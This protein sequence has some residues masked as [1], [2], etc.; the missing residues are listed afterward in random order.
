[1][2]RLPG[3]TGQRHLILEKTTPMLP[4]ARSRGTGPNPGLISAARIEAGESVTPARA[5]A[6]RQRKEAEKDGQ[7]E[8]SRKPLDQD[9]GQKLQIQKGGNIA[10]A[11]KGPLKRDQKGQKTTRIAT[12]SRGQY[13][14]Q[15]RL[16]A[17]VTRT[18]GTVCSA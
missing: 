4:E 16:V 9:N 18:E 5:R 3:E 14:T 13:S 17:R 12:E 15:L 10:S 1:M 7:G 6:S 8:G 11:P 2:A